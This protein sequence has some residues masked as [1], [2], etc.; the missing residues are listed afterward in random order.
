M[1]SD[2]RSEFH[3]IANPSS[4]ERV[5]NNS[6]YTDSSNSNN[7][8]NG[9]YSSSMTDNIG[10]AQRRKKQRIS[11]SCSMCR[12]RK[13]K[14]DEQ[15]PVCG[16]C[17][18]SGVPKHK[19]N[20]NEASPWMQS[21]SNNPE[22]ENL[23]SVKSQLQSMKNMIKRLEQ[24]IESASSNPSVNIQD[25]NVKIRGP[26]AY[27]MPILNE[28]MDLR[29]P[30]FVFNNGGCDTFFTF[31]FGSTFARHEKFLQKVKMFSDIMFESAKLWK[32]NSE[33][34]MEEKNS[35]ESEYF[36]YQTE[37][38]E[39]DNFIRMMSLILPKYEG[40]MERFKYFQKHLSII[41]DFLDINVVEGYLKANFK[42]G[43]MG[44]IIFHK[45]EKSSIY[46]EAA[47]VLAVIALTTLFSTEH[48]YHN[49]YKDTLG[50]LIYLTEKAL[51][52]S[53]FLRKQSIPALQTLL[54]LRAIKVYDPKRVYELSLRKEYSIFQEAL[55]ISVS[56]G[57]H[58]DPESIRAMIYKDIQLPLSISKRAWRKTWNSIKILD[59]YYSS[60]LVTPQLIEQQFSDCSSVGIYEHN[61]KILKLTRGIVE[62]LCSEVDPISI[63]EIIQCLDKLLK[64]CAFEIDPFEDLIQ[65]NSRY[66]PTE[67]ELDVMVLKLI[68][69]LKISE[70]II[71]LEAALS[72]ILLK[73]DFSDL[74]ST[75]ISESERIAMKSLG[76]YYALEANKLSLFIFSL[77][78][79]CL[80]PYN[81]YEG[82][83]KYLK[84][85][86]PHLKTVLYF[87]F[88]LILSLSLDATPIPTKS[89]YNDSMS[90]RS[91]PLN[92]ELCLYKEVKSVQLPEL[93]SLDKKIEDCLSDSRLN[94]IL[95]CEFLIKSVDYI[96]DRDFFVNFKSFM[97][98]CSYTRE[99]AFTTYLMGET[100]SIRLKERCK[101]I[102]GDSK[103]D[104][105][106][107]SEK[108]GSRS[109]NE[110]YD[111]LTNGVDSRLFQI[112]SIQTFEDFKCLLKCDEEDV[113]ELDLDEL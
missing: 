13:I 41:F 79:K 95:I 67:E 48:T 5:S 33:D 102:T 34:S 108:L 32:D 38:F 53:S 88:F 86:T 39:E 91:I 12:S 22:N 62:R 98:L 107:L 25:T 42:V 37:S 50:K 113:E 8:N 30:S 14:C 90:V 56:M 21:M 58:R 16:S 99:V 3:S 59:D 11:F 52:L 83:E 78:S 2:I 82:K 49:P 44:E 103:A 27:D 55:N 80:S 72:T 36:E 97:L 64:F 15:K 18:K 63:N 1:G 26:S 7:N 75:K 19:C 110:V 89:L 85:I 23:D 104:I 77:C 96:G 84:L 6:G 109:I 100:P 54:I 57:L 45:L 93:L 105:S 94:M 46:S 51:S 69:K 66:S 74:S 71:S 60:R 81:A 31:S 43:L 24:Q 28:L 70:M 111:W 101:M 106:I 35:S 65:K 112:Y 9:R 40:I 47:L 61:T 73:D 76:R 87:S 92:Y 20:Y 4:L 10:N 68:S 17:T 29:K